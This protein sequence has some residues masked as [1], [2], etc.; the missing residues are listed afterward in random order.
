MDLSPNLYPLFHPPHP[1]G[2]APLGEDEGKGCPLP[3]PPPAPSSAR[4][5]LLPELGDGGGEVGGAVGDPEA[6]VPPQG[7]LQAMGRVPAVVA[8][9]PGEL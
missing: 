9:C 2:V 4:P 3:P 1:K 8:F 6:P 7:V 5:A